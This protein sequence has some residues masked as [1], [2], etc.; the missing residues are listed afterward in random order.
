MTTKYS[1][2]TGRGITDQTQVFSG[3]KTFSSPAL[4]SGRVDGS[5]V[6]AGYIGEV[7]EFIG[8]NNA[9]SS[10]SGDYT[11]VTTT[12]VPAGVYLVHFIMAAI[13]PTAG[14]TNFVVAEVTTSAGLSPTTDTGG[15]FNFNAIGE[16]GDGAPQITNGKKQMHGWT[17]MTH[18]SPTVYFLRANIGITAGTVEYRG[19]MR[20]IRIA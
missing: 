17:T 6:S 11:A 13:A 9:F 19:A 8:G 3:A 5:T 18:S 16:T 20:F 7:I 2:N 12:A 4:F 15:S 14:T 10:S 1:S